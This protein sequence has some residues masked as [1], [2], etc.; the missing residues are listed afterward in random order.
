MATRHHIVTA[1]AGEKGYFSDISIPAVEA[2]MR[3][4]GI[5]QDDQ[6]K[7]LMQVRHLYHHFRDTDNE[8]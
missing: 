6:W 2:A 5:R 4:R 8:D 1:P 7:V 3:I